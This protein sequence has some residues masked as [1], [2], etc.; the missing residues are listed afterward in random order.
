MPLCAAPE[1]MREAEQS[2][3]MALVRSLS[4]GNQANGRTRPSVGHGWNREF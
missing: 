2:Q 3:A 4:V 1:P